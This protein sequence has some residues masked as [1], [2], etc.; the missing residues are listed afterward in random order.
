MKR[1]S[2]MERIT[3]ETRVM[4]NLTIDGSGEYQIHSGLPFFDHMLSQLAKH[5]GF[6][7]QLEAQ[8]DLEVD[9]HHTVEDVG[10]VLGQA[11]RQILGDS[12]GI[13]RFGHALIPMD[14]VLSRVAVDLSGRG[15]LYTDVPFSNT[16]VGAFPTELVEEFLRALAIQ[17]GITLHVEL[18][19]GRNTHHQVEAVFKALGQSLKMAFRRDGSEILPSTKGML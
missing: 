11:I 14:D 18:L 12:R 6:D 7:L 16:M 2:Q 15:Y 5:G 4:V 3:K 9:A 13:Q 1:Q 8:G 17:G 19:H 10:I